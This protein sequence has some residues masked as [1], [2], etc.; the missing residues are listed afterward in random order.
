V[1]GNR[2]TLN[3]RCF[4]EEK[5]LASVV[6]RIRLGEVVHPGRSS[7]WEEW[8]RIRTRRADNN[9]NSF[10]TVIDCSVAPQG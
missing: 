1:G 4:A 6:E 7:R 5:V 8:F 2:K 9:F 10:T 3:R